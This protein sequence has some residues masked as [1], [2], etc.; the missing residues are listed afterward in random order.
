MPSDRDEHESSDGG[1]GL[2]SSLLVLQI[3]QI[4]TFWDING[5][6]KLILDVIRKR[7]APK[8]QWSSWHDSLVHISRDIIFHIF[9][10]H[11]PPEGYSSK[12]QKKLRNFPNHISYERARAYDIKYSSPWAAFWLFPEIWFFKVRN[13]Y[14]KFWSL[15]VFFKISK[16][17]NSSD[18]QTQ[19]NFR[20]MSI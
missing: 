19:C 15:G 14:L 11:F 9:K 5:K 4:W 6:K 2:A 16:K 8:D 18:F 10:I 3:F 7:R 1:L 17:I 13:F 20:E 12:I